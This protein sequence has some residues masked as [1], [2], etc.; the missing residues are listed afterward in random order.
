[1]AVAKVALALDQR[2]LDQQNTLLTT[3][4]SSMAGKPAFAKVEPTPA[5]VRAKCDAALAQR[6]LRNKLRAQLKQAETDLDTAEAEFARVFTALGAGVDAVAQG[7]AA[8]IESAGMPASEPTGKRPAQTPEMPTG[9][10]VTTG[11]AAGEAD[12]H[13]NGVKGARAYEVHYG[14]TPDQ[15]THKTTVFRSKAELT[16]LLPGQEVWVAVVAKGTTGDS[17]ATAPARG[18]AGQQN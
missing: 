14:N 10:T 12:P 2:T 6:T 18:Y 5:D 15:L 4:E 16:G 9:L 8:V 1:M 11:D 17:P 13:W 7:A 3:I